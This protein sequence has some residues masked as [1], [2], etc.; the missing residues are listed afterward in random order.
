MGIGV[1]YG[2]NF[3]QNVNFKRG[4]PLF[5]C[6]HSPIIINGK[7]TQ[8][9]TFSMGINMCLMFRKL[10]IWFY[11]RPHSLTHS[12]EQTTHTFIRHRKSLLHRLLFVDHTN[13]FWFCRLAELPW[14]PW[15]K[16][17]T[18]TYITVSFLS[19][20]TR[21]LVY[22][23]TLS[24]SLSPGNFFSLPL[25]WRERSNKVGIWN[26]WESRSYLHTFMAF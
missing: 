26:M 7:H 10:L 2:L 12:H 20:K 5:F 3:P 14:L 16:S 11:Y 19:N 18:T 8:P 4:L 1:L 17:C 6:K 25:S 15:I 21:F 23:K 24:L 9:K 22:P 13:A